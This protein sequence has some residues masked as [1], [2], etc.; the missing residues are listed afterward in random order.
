MTTTQTVDCPYCHKHA[1]LV[2]GTVIYPHRPDLEDRK[3]WLCRPCRA[4]VGT[5]RDSPD[6][7]PLGRL[8]DATLRVWKQRVHEVFDPLWKGEEKKMKRSEAYAVLAARMGIQIDECHIGMFDV[9]RCK[10]AERIVKEWNE[11]ET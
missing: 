9:E 3:F 10:A 5:H 1:E 8:A 7:K 11:K 2:D 6:H 4:Y